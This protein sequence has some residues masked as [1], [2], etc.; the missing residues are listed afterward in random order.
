MLERPVECNGAGFSVTSIVPIGSAEVSARPWFGTTAVGQSVAQLG[1]QSG[2]QHPMS[3]W[4][5]PV[6]EDAAMGHS[7]LETAKAGPEARAKEM[8][9]TIKAIRRRTVE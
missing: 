6:E 5:I 3:S 4:L 9:S 7:T 8:A 1:A 2:L